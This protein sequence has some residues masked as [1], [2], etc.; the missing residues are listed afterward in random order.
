MSSSI[1]YKDGDGNTVT[2]FLQ[3]HSIEENEQNKINAEN[4]ESLWRLK[5]LVVQ[6]DLLS[7]GLQP[8]DILIYSFIQQYLPN[9]KNRSFFFSNTKLANMFGVSDK[10]I[11][12]SLKRIKDKGFITIRH[13]TLPNGQSVRFVLFPDTGGQIV[14]TPPPKLSV[15]P[16]Q[17]DHQ[18]ISINDKKFNDIQANALKKKNYKT[19]EWQA[20]ATY[21]KDKMNIPDSANSSF[22]K[23][24]KENTNKAE[25]AARKTVDSGANRPELMFFKNYHNL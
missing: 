25:M 17:N 15:P 2:D 11:R 4:A 5:F 3:A 24:F 21:W 22:F 6:T 14:R 13:K 19:E 8:I 12:R 10:T 1:R 23:L 16:S 9:S 7:S 20:I 18:M